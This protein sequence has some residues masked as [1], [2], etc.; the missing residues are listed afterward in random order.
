VNK[1]NLDGDQYQFQPDEIDKYKNN[2]R[3]FYIAGPRAKDNNGDIAN[4]Y[5]SDGDEANNEIKLEVRIPIPSETFL[6]EISQEFR[7]HPISVYLLLDEPIGDKEANRRLFFCKT[8]TYARFLL[9]YARPVRG[10]AR[11]SFHHTTLG[12]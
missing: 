8:A 2:L 10:G 7:I 6:E 9:A 12:E 3:L 11:M 5:V 1:Y 4:T